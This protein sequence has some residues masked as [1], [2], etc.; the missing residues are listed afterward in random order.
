[1]KNV[2]VTGAN[3]H[4][5]YNLVQLLAEKGYQVRASVRDKR[6]QSLIKPL[7]ALGVE[8]VEADIMKP[9]TLPAAVKGID[10]VFQVAAVYTM[11]SEN[12]QRDIIDPSVVGGI[13]VLT[14]ARDAGVKKVVFTS[15]VA[16][17]GSNA[18]A[19]RPLTEDD[20]NDSAQSPYMIAKTQAER[21]AWEFA[22]EHNLNLVCINPSSVLGPGFF[23]HTPSTQLFEM[24]LRGQMPMVPPFCFSYV[25]VRDVAMA[26]LL[27]Y[28]NEKAT[29]RYIIA[30]QTFSLMDVLR[31]A[32]QIDNKVKAPMMIVPSPFVPMLPYFDWVGNK[33]LG[34]PRQLTAEMLRDFQGKKQY[35]SNQR[36][37]RELGWQP[38][39]FKESLR[40]T[41]NW[42]HKTFI[43]NN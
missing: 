31:V 29:G 15:S 11:Y 16:A 34:L 23:R 25:D 18:S 5:G 2:L 37:R 12:P 43:N 3:G 36:A 1:M 33:L 9:E 19:E 7:S 28:E 21:R 42:I 8:I 10:G 24:A 6:N 40:D 14:A 39:D 26:H 41:L 32:K 30:D 4:V 13:N 35:L 27:A 17:I 20:W 38:M 22:R